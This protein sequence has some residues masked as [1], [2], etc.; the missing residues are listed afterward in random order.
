MD[1]EK[2]NRSVSLLCPT[3]GNSEFGY[4][5]DDLSRGIRC[6]S[7]GRIFSRDELIKDNGNIIAANVEE[8]GEEFVKDA[9][10]E[11]RTMLQ[12][13]FSGSKI[14]KVK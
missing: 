13:A 14:F 7:C 12:K 2:Y 1:S 6:L 8:I 10:D 4:D 5:D 11:L 3:C 9:A